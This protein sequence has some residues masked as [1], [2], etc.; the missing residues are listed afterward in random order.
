MV[1][2]GN[3]PTVQIKSTGEKERES[4]A[5]T[6]RKKYGRGSAGVRSQENIYRQ[7][8]SPDGL[9]HSELE[10]SESHL[11]T[12][13]DD[14]ANSL[15]SEFEIT[16]SHLRTEFDDVSNSLRSEFEVTASHLRTEFDDISNSLR[17]EFETTA[18]HLRT[19]FDDMSN[20]LRG[21]FEVSASHLRT[22]F[23]D[24]ANSLRGEFEVTASHLRNEFIDEATSLRSEF[25][26]TA[27]HLR[28]EFIDE[29]SSLRSEFVVTASFMRREFEDEVNSVRSYTEQTASSWETRVEGVVDENGNITAASICLAVNDGQST[30]TINASK[31]YMLGQTILNTVDA[32]Y[33]YTTISSIASLLVQD[34]TAQGIDA[35]S[36]SIRPVGGMGAVSVATAYN[37][38]SLSQSGNTYTLRLVKMNGQFDEYSF[39]RAT[40]L[41]GDWASGVFTTTASPQG[42]TLTTSLTNTGHWGSTANGENP[43]H[44]YYKTYATIGSSSVPVDTGN[45]Y[46]IDAST[47]LQDKTGNA[48]FT[49]N[50]T[51]T[52]DSGY[53]GYGEITIDVPQS[54]GAQNVDVRFNGS[55][56]S[57]YIEAFDNVSGNPISGAN[58]T[59][60]LGLSGTTVQVQ[61]VSGTLIG[62]QFQIPLQSS[63]TLTSNGTYTPSSGNVG[64]SSVTVDVP[65]DLPN[66]RTRFSGSSGQYYVESFDSVSGNSISGSSVT[67][68]LGTSGASVQIQNS[69][70]SQI[71]GTPTLALTIDNG[72]VDASGSRTLTVVVGGVNTT[73]TTTITDYAGGWSDAYAKVSLP[74]NNTE[75]GFM[76]V[77]TPPSTVG[78]NATETTYTLDTS[79]NNVAYIKVG[80]SVKAQ[81]THNKY[82]SGYND[83]RLTLSNKVISK[84]TAG[85]ITQ[86]T[87]ALVLENRSTTSGND[88]GKRKVWIKATP[89]SGDAVEVSSS[90][91]SKTISIKKVIG[92]VLC[93]LM[94]YKKINHKH[95]NQNKINLTK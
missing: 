60:K 53:I 90:T 16:A 15:R 5:K 89:N 37:G 44:Y 4:V 1:W 12:E 67:Y 77:K 80:S 8:T 22:E 30:A 26:I 21:E 52:A 65:S 25:E 51:Y 75:T 81:V 45:P 13:F 64:M 56:G 62:A 88:Y 28:N 87:L 95:Y 84:T 40:S 50:G 91:N 31:I 85:S 36:V 38:S 47:K 92:T 59:Y 46:E 17:G 71:S 14:V 72:S 2:K 69:S 78:G 27:S 49:A 54:T 83:A 41:S 58:K 93:Y 82:T 23:N 32:N 33:I 39:S 55:S 35:N 43:T 20:S 10:I 6:S 57:Y 70:G 7:F 29:T 74:A 18:S 42:N 66:A 73:R 76:V 63:R 48:K 61:D 24:K 86:Y 68:K 3:S 11:R 94:K 79:S 34:I 19:E 9:L